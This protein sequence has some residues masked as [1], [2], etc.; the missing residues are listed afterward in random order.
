MRQ[1]YQNKWY[2]K[3]IWKLETA[4]AYCWKTCK[5]KVPKES[6]SWGVVGRREFESMGCDNKSIIEASCPKNSGEKDVA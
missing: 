1:K 3:Y 4:P 5:V 2:K 6:R